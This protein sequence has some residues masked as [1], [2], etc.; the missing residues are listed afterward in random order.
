MLKDG[1][2]IIR[3]WP[4]VLVTASTVLAK[5]LILRQQ[6]NSS[7]TAGASKFDHQLLT[8]SLLQ[9]LSAGILEEL[10][11]RWLYVLPLMLFWQLA[12]TVEWLVLPTLSALCIACVVVCCLQSASGHP[13][14][15]S[16]YQQLMG[17]GILLT[18]GLVLLG[19]YVLAPTLPFVAT[20]LGCLV[21]CYRRL[22]NLFTLGFMDYLWGEAA[23]I[24]PAL[25]QAFA[26]SALAFHAAHLDQGPLGST[27]VSVMS[28]ALWHLT[29]HW[30]LHYAMACHCLYDLAVLSAPVVA[31]LLGVQL[32]PLVPE[33][34]LWL[35]HRAV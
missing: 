13:A 17:E 1:S 5:V 19:I 29:L 33:L 11:L 14:P 8:I 23:R 9:S 22:L 30:G 4:L 26:T 27:F 24:S 6:Q 16:P 12:G 32:A 3:M 25:L 28:G 31:R 10:T 21:S 35:R 34:P 2:S 7:I 20:P 18:T 15:Q